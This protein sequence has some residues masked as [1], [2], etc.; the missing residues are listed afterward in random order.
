MDTVFYP[1][2]PAPALGAAIDVVAGD[3]TFPICDPVTRLWRPH[4]LHRGQVG[5]GAT[6][7]ASVGANGVI[8]GITVTNPG[9]GY[10]SPPAPAVTITGAGA[11]ATA[12]AVVTLSGV[13][14]AITVDA[15]G[16]GYTAPIVKIGT[17]I[18]GG[19]LPANQATATATGG[20]EDNIVVSSGGSLY[21]FP[22][23]E[24]DMPGD[25]NGAQAQ[26]HAVLW[27]FVRR[28]PDRG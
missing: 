1:A 8:T 13:V 19:A 17:L 18:D 20:V 23:V 22:V 4:L 14:T 3:A 24:F 15:A 28:H 16:T 7:V 11:G 21:T 26:G 2:G 10:T 12:E 6:A 9:S 25:P 5:A 27:A